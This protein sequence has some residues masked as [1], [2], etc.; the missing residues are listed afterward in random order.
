MD[1]KMPQEAL[2]LNKYAILI[3]FEN[4]LDLNPTPFPQNLPNFWGM[5]IQLK[6]LI[7]QPLSTTSLFTILALKAILIF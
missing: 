3:F 5:P 2:D 1:K 4:I 6:V 7:I